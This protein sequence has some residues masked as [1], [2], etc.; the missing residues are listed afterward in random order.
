[1]TFSRREPSMAFC[2]GPDQLRM[3]NS[4]LKTN[5]DTAWNR[6]RGLEYSP[7]SGPKTDSTDVPVTSSYQTLGDCVVT[8]MKMTI[9]SSL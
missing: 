7:T 6:H 9:M 1:M 5:E 2:P 8:E 4:H 3:R